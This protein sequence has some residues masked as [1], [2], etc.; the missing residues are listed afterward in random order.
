MKKMKFSGGTV[1]GIM[2]IAVGVI[3]LLSELDYLNSWDVFSE[4]WPLFIV[5]IGISY[6]LD[7]KSSSFFGVVLIVIGTLFQIDKLKVDVFK[8]IDMSD[9]ILPTIIILVGL[10][11]ILPNRTKLKETEEEP[12]QQSHKQPEE[13]V[14]V[15]QAEVKKAE[16]VDE[17]DISVE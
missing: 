15:K 16:V 9:M 14:E 7:Y 5:L 11:F 4:Y 13:T 2:L 12:V 17:S 1:F 3:S 10:K 8:D 6:L